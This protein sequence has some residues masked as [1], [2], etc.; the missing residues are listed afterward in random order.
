[1]NSRPVVFMDSGIGGIPYCRHFL[2]RNPAEKIIYLADRLNF[3][4][5]EKTGEE[6]ARILSGHTERLIQ[7]ADPKIIVLA[8]NTATVC[9]LAILREKFPAIP[10]VGTVP[11]VKPAV[12]ASKTKIIGVLATERTIN[13][14]YVTD[15]AH[16]FGQCT[17]QGIAAGEL[18]EFVEKKFDTAT[19]SEK[20]ELVRK[21]LD[22]MRKLNADVLVLGCTHFLALADVFHRE[23]GS[24]IKVFDSVEGVSH[25]IES[26]LD[27]SNGALRAPAGLPAEN[28]FL[29][30]GNEAP[31]EIWKRRAEKF[32][33]ALSLLEEL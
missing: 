31:D 20:T 27:E 15:L 2:S 10:F 22:R 11:A 21:Y 30:S 33:F 5:G 12:L 26:L 7:K 25:R 16:S 3:P 4:Y 24:D 23:A 1:M 6:I 29:L 32:G 9:G 18:V 8:C 14:R 19:D 13:D 28:R 17:V